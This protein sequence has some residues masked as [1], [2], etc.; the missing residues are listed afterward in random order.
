MDI[1]LSRSLICS[2][3]Q[4]QQRQVRRV[5][6]QYAQPSDVMSA[7][8]LGL[9]HRLKALMGKMGRSAP[10][11]ATGRRLAGAPNLAEVRQLQ[12]QLGDLAP[13]LTV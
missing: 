12:T 8:W 2:G 7:V 11:D 10:A 5:L 9:S 4:Q 1:C 13:E 6:R 3:R